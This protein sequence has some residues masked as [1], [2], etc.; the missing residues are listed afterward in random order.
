MKTKVRVSYEHH[1]EE[2]NRVL[3]ICRANVVSYMKRKVAKRDRNIKSLPVATYLL[4]IQ[5]AII[6]VH[7]V[8]RGLSV[9]YVHEA[10][11]SDVGRVC[12]SYQ[13]HHLFASHLK[14]K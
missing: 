10:K 8:G 14:S 6:P 7:Q 9:S 12:V 1:N 5:E 4:I 3:N 11:C 2:K 13:T